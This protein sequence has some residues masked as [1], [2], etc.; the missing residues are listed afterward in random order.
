[1]K[2]HGTSQLQDPYA[3]IWGLLCD[4]LL[5]VVGVRAKCYWIGMRVEYTL[6]H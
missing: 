6:V 3:E 5:L 4:H 2:D 1:M